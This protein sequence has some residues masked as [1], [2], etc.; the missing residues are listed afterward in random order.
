M[1]QRV[2]RAAHGSHRSREDD[3]DGDVAAV[4]Q[5]KNR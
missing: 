4:P 3:N 5:F 1:A 2:H